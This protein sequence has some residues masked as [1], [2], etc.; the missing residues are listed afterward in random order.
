MFEFLRRI[1][2]WFSKS[3]VEEHSVPSAQELPY[4]SAGTIT[5]PV[6]EEEC[7]WINI[8]PIHNPGGA[9][10]LDGCTCGHAGPPHGD[11]DIGGGCPIAEHWN[12]DP[13]KDTLA[14]HLSLYGWI[15]PEKPEWP[16]K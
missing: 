9:Y 11:G 12:N 6:E 8:C 2:G 10:I 3:K 14:Y 7:E 15:P 13:P 5:E 16:M 4:R 1:F